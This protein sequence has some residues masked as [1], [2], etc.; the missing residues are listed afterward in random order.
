MRNG[1]NKSSEAY[2]SKNVI[3]S[4]DLYRYTG[5]D[6]MSTKKGKFRLIFMPVGIVFWIFGWCLSRV[7][8]TD[9]P[10]KTHQLKI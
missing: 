2:F 7:G 10:R 8:F 1:I 9:K 5:K 3:L 6:N 4:Q